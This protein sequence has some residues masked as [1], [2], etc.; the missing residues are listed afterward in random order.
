MECGC[1]NSHI[2]Q[3]KNIKSKQARQTP[4][5][6]PVKANV[7]CNFISIAAFAELLREHWSLRMNGLAANKLT[8]TT[9]F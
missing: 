9:H 4:S 5:N 3:N 2:L 7:D 8:K 6:T 1:K